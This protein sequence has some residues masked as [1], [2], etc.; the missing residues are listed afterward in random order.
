M[1]INL[2]MFDNAICKS[3]NKELEHMA[4]SIQ[5]ELR[6]RDLFSNTYS[7]EGLIE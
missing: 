1:N 3:S 7:N 6:E 5:V 2:D 4:A